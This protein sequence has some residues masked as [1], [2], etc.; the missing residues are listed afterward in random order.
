MLHIAMGVMALFMNHADIL[1]MKAVKDLIWVDYG[2]LLFANDL[3][4]GLYSG[5]YYMEQT[6]RAKRHWPGCGMGWWRDG[7]GD[8]LLRHF[9]RDQLQ[10]IFYHLPRDIFPCRQ[11][12]IPVWRPYDNSLSGWFLVEHQQ[13][14]GGITLVLGYPSLVR[15]FCVGCVLTSEHSFRF[16]D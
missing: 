13:L 11:L 8:M 7:S 14:V 6:R 9:R 5:H 2:L 12:A 10:L 4:A 1:H 16:S 15:G 3:L